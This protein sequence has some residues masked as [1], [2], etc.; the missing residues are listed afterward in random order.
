LVEGV[1]GVARPIALTVAGAADPIQLLDLAT[2]LI[3][4]SA[5]NLLPVMGLGLHRG[6]PWLVSEFN[7]GVDLE[8]F[9]ETV[10]PSPAQALLLAGDVLS[11]IGCLHASD[12]VHT[13]VHPGNI[14]I[15]LDGVARLGD[16]AA[17][18]IPNPAHATEQRRVDLVGSADAI[19]RLAVASRCPAGAGSEEAKLLVGLPR[20]LRARPAVDG[21]HETVTLVEAAT[22]DEVHRCDLREELVALVGAAVG[23]RGRLPQAGSDATRSPTRALA[24]SGAPRDGEALPGTP[25]VRLVTPS[26]TDGAV[27]AVETVAPAKRGSKFATG[28]FPRMIRGLWGLVLAV[29]VLGLLVGLEVTFLKGP[30]SRDL[31]TLRGGQAP[32]ASGTHRTGPIPLVGPAVVRGTVT[33]LDVRL[34][35]ACMANRPCPVRVLVG[36]TPQPRPLAVAWRFE[37]IDRCSGTLVSR[38]GGEA[39][40]PAGARQ[41]VRLGSVPLPAWRS[42]EVVV[43]TSAPVTA[44]SAGFA[45]PISGGVC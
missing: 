20:R 23:S 43:L 8:R 36:F 21:W 40:L 26:G 13:R 38:A 34:L 16:W 28:T 27:G 33:A 12:R 5:P 11:G 2:A 39:T 18:E 37:V 31:Q 6:R 25:L 22:G 45:V 4:L 32:K 24:P 30:V 29:A 3:G 35:G 15:G 17:V 9:V 10:R 44:R 41:L 1:E 19:G 14:Q 7:R 42:S